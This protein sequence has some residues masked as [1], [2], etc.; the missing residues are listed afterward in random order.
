M[1]LRTVDKIDDLDLG[2]KSQADTVGT[3]FD[4]DASCVGAVLEAG[5]AS[6]SSGKRR[7]STAWRR[8]DFDHVSA[9]NRACTLV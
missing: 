8:L 3:L 5:R 7:V 6:G 1:F 9:H 2:R 4:G